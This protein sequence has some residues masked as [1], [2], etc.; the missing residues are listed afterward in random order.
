M[1]LN[2][3]RLIFLGDLESYVNDI[4]ANVELIFLIARYLLVDCV[5]SHCLIG[6]EDAGRE[7]KAKSE[8]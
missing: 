5:N 4:K 3:R 2:M 1:Q 7:K 8:Q 6:S